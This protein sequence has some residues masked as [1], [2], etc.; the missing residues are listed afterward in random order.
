MFPVLAQYDLLVYFLG[1]GWIAALFPV[2]PASLAGRRVGLTPASKLAAELAGFW[3]FG[4]SFFFAS[5]TGG[6]SVAWP[7]I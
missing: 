7:G 3:R 2:A 1:L 5:A 6:T 4:L